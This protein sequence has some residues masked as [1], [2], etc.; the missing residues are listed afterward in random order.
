MLLEGGKNSGEEQMAAGATAGRARINR[1]N[2]TTLI[3]E[4]I[5]GLTSDI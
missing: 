3:R 2:F 1:L 5:T 4:D